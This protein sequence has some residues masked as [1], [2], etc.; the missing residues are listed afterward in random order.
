M[1]IEGDG[2]SE[3]SSNKLQVESK[4]RA[5]SRRGSTH[6]VNMLSIDETNQLNIPNNIRRDSTH[7]N[8]GS[9]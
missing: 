8:G 3:K 2:T 9:R 7:S 5:G 4:S 6:D 1:K